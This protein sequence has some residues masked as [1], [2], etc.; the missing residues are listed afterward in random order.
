MPEGRYHP[1]WS[2]QPANDR[3]VSV[4][5]GSERRGRGRREF[6]FSTFIAISLR[7]DSDFMP[8]GFVFCKKKKKHKAT[9]RQLNGPVAQCRSASQTGG[10]K[11]A[12]S[13]RGEVLGNYHADKQKCLTY[14]PRWVA[15]CVS[16]GGCR[17]KQK[18][19]RKR[20]NIK[21]NWLCNCWFDISCLNDYYIYGGDPVRK[22]QSQVQ[23][24]V[25]AFEGGG[26]KATK[27]KL[28]K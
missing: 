20:R 28:L 25:V 24:R 21:P 10:F 1:S 13:S 12:S 5:R 3:E 7:R 23:R 14:D 11:C 17:C 8:K 22:E 19:E 4:R 27:E 2:L 26:K 16:V 9:R 15:K 6:V 18:K